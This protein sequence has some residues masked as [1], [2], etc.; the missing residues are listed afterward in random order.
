MPAHPMVSRSRESSIYCGRKSWA[1][2][3]LRSCRALRQGFAATN[4]KERQ[5]VVWILSFKECKAARTHRPVTENI[6]SPLESLENA[7]VSVLRVANRF[8]FVFV[9]SWNVPR[10]CLFFWFPLSL[11]TSPPRVHNLQLFATFSWNK[12]QI[13]VIFMKNELESTLEHD[14]R[15]PILES[16]PFLI[17][18]ARSDVGCRAQQRQ[19]ATQN[20]GHRRKTNVLTQ[21]G[22]CPIRFLVN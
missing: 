21:F 15:A 10:E 2:L 4:R 16:A 18:L 22:V 5:R 9:L 12:T 7:Y 19:K 8:S 11:S 6:Q 17:N 3:F 1:H 13:Q 14:T 20:L